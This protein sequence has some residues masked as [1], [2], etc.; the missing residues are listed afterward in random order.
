MKKIMSILKLIFSGKRLYVSVVAG[1]VITIAI[2][3]LALKKNSDTVSYQ[4]INPSKEMVVSSVSA[5]GKIVSTNFLNITTSASGVVSKVYVKDGDMVASGQKIAD[6][7]LDGIGRQKR[8]AAYASYLS[9]ANAVKSTEISLY[10]LQSSMFAANQKLVNDAAAR[11]LASTDPTYIQQNADWLAS[12]A[13]YKE[14]SNI[15]AQSKVSL[16]S[17]FLSYQQSSSGVYAHNSGIV[18]NITLV[19]GLNLDG[20]ST[21]AAVVRNSG[22]PKAIFNITEIDVVRIKPG[23]KATIKVDSLTDKTFTGKV[24]TVDKIGTT[25]NNV[26]TYP[27]IVEFDTQI[28]EILPNMSASASIIIATKNDVLTIPT[29]AIQTLN[30][31]STVKILVDGKES[32]KTIEAGLT[33]DSLTEIVSGV[34]ESDQV[35]ISSVKNTTGSSSSGTTIFGGGAQGS[36]RFMMAR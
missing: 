22:L 16:S 32:I 11:G 28:A 14:Q 5:S 8:D 21:R 9:A 4:T 30:G 1:I 25:A 15:I 34:S 20:T 36:Q 23:L 31:V 13:K 29:S 24:V 10:T 7:E 26:T 18:D 17:S 2:G 35:I 33:G 6:I 27:V 12:E 19:Q 3:F